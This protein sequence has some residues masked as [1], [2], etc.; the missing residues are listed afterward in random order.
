MDIQVCKYCGKPF[1]PSNP[2]KLQDCCSKSCA[3]KYRW[4]TRDG[5]LFDQDLDWK[6]DGDVWSCPYNQGVGCRTRR[7]AGCG[8]N[9]VVEKTRNAKLGVTV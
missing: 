5:I 1:T 8:W 4:E 2:S 6:K 9:P 3:A 7:C